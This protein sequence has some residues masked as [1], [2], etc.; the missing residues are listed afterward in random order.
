[1]APDLESM[2]H[3]AKQLMP[4]ILTVAE[5]AAYLRLG[6]RKLY[7]L[8]QEQ[9]IPVARVDGR[10]L[11]PRRLLDGW[12]QSQVVG[13]VRSD[14]PPVLAGS[15]DPLLEWAARE[16]GSG[17]ALLAGGSG[18][19]LRRLAAGTAMVAGLHI[20]DLDG[21]YNIAAVRG[22]GIADLV[23]IGWAR[24]RQG[25]VLPPG[26][27]KDIR[28]LADIPKLGLRLARRQPEAG[29][30]ILLGQLLEAAAV[31]PE[32]IA[33]TEAV[34]H[35]ET[36]LAAAV[37]DG[38]ADAGL[39][40][41]AVARRFRLAFLPLAEERFD[42]VMPRRVY[43]EPPVQKLLSF[44]RSRAFAEHAAQLGG[45]ATAECGQVRFNG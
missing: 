21:D 28:S 13:P 15:H 4:E 27:P 38:V 17:L 39:A 6:Q 24:R 14:P 5:A 20:R 9:R 12:L 42:L 40:I 35:T 31:D 18:D 37:L 16:S 1:M 19:G 45:Y 34:L 44:T 10:L 25:L 30:Q 11:F 26:N 23:L 32:G 41:E 3:N 33:W 7:A 29:A 36:D 8:V 22:L 2:Q 43:F